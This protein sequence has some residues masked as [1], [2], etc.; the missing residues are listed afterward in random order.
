MQ[1]S[2]AEILRTVE[3]VRETGT[4][5]PVVASN[6]EYPTA[7][8]NLRFIREAYARGADAVQLHPPT[9]GHSFAPDAT[10]LRSFYADVLSATAVPVVLSSN[11]M[12]GFEVPGEVLEAQVREYPHVIGVFT[13]HPDQHRVAAL[14]QRLVPHTTV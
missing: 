8:D 1:M 9:L 10:M 14:T 4:A 2:D 11:F 6:R 13:H 3:L 12:T 5:G 7:R